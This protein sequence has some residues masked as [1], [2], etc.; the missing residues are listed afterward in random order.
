MLRT[1]EIRGGEKSKQKEKRRK[2]YL[3]LIL[4]VS[5]LYCAMLFCLDQFLQHNSALNDNHVSAPP[6]ERLLF[7][8]LFLSTRRLRFNRRNRGS[9]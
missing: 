6:V 5:V 3:Q 8:C 9:G 2:A 7:L 1:C 4:A